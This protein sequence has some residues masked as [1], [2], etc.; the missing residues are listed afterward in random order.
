MIKF[1]RTLAIAAIFTVSAISAQATTTCSVD[2]EGKA[3]STSWVVNPPKNFSDIVRNK[4]RLIAFS[5]LSDGKVYVHE[6]PSALLT[7]FGDDSA[8]NLIQKINVVARDKKTGKE[9]SVVTSPF[10]KAGPS[11]SGGCDA[12]FDTVISLP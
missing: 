5:A 12:E 11:V 10:S 4:L 2:Q 1:P 9:C 7:C 8:P 6:L 3:K